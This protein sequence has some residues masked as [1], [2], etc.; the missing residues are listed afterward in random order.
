M[1]SG[2]LSVGHTCELPDFWPKGS[3]PNLRTDVCPERRGGHPY[4]NASSHSGRCAG[5]RR[6]AQLRERECAAMRMRL[7]NLQSL[8]LVR[9]ALILAGVGLTTLTAAADDWSGCVNGTA[10]NAVEACTRA[11]AYAFHR[12][13]NA[14]F[15]AQDRQHAI[16]DFNH[17]IKIDPNYA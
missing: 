10:N 12:R 16:E 14:F 1:K 6:I 3:Q 15:D 17:A 11:I 2:C 5:E 9:P 13:A 4:R 8:L 7:V